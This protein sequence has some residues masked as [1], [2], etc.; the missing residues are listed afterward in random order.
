M[1]LRD[2]VRPIWRFLPGAAEGLALGFIILEER[3][4]RILVG[5]RAIVGI[6]G[7]V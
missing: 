3:L 7:E 1:D 5:R 2:E 6:S 4:G